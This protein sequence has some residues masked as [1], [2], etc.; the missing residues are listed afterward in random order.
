MSTAPRRKRSPSAAK[1]IPAPAPIPQPRFVAPVPDSPVRLEHP[2][3]YAGKTYSTIILRRPSSGVLG[4]WFERLADATSDVSEVST[5]PPIFVHPD[6]E[7]VPDVVLASLDDDDRTA[8]FVG[9]DPF[10][11]RR[12]ASTIE[13]LANVQ[14]PSDGVSPAPTSSD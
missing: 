13:L 7:L 6:G 8:V 2:L 14:A 12:L 5:M 11:P 3:E 1:P 10:L 4:R 9:A